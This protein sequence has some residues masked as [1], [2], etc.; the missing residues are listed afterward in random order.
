MWPFKKRPEPTSE[1]FLAKN[2]YKIVEETEEFDELEGE[3]WLHL[4]DGTQ[5]KFKK[6]GRIKYQIPSPY[7]LITGKEI[8]YRDNVSYENKGYIN[9]YLQYVPPAIYVKDY[10][11]NKIIRYTND[12]GVEVEVNQSMV[13]QSSID[14]KPTG[15]KVTGT[16]GKIVKIEKV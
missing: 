10:D 15:K 8:S 6:L 16:K 5:V 4:I 7:S 14:I 9:A 13:L 12:S 2:I 11:G 3:V 1:E